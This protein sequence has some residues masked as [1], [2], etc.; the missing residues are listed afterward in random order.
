MDKGGQPPFPKQSGICIVA[1]NAWCLFEDLEKAPKA[2]II[3][4]N[5]SSREVKAFA[6]FSYHPERF[7]EP[8]YSWI[9]RQ[10]KFRLDFT[11]HA[12]NH[13]KNGDLSFVDYWWEGARGHGGS[14]WGARKVAKLMGFEQVILCG[15]PLTPGNY[16]GHRPGDLM[17]RQSVVD[18][19]ASEIESDKEWHEGCTSMSGATREILGC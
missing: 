11:V 16:T 14:A 3:A 18:R 7:I 10:Q 6:L 2:P 9:K 5:G 4:I 1:G 8:P 13:K 17:T 15:C 12:T 19:Y